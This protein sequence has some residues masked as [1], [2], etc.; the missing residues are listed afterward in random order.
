MVETAKMERML[1][2]SVD[3]VK[4]RAILCGLVLS[5]RIGFS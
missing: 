1:E 2:F 5:D 3:S 4:L